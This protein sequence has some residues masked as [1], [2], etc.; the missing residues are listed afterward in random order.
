MAAG[1]SSLFEAE[2][3]KY[4]LEGK[5]LKVV[6]AG[7]IYLG[8]CEVKSKKAADFAA[9]KELKGEAGK[10]YPERKAINDALLKMEAKEQAGELGEANKGARVINSAEAKVFTAVP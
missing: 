5:A 9:M 10:G 7:K 8:F 3:A 6:E 4:L 2:I 1:G